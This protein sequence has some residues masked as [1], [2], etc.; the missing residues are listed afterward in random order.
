[1]LSKAAELNVKMVG[2]LP[3][4]EE[5]QA[6]GID[7]PYLEIFQFCNPADAMKMVAYDPIYSAYMPCR[8]ALSEDKDGKLWLLTLNMDL[9]IDKFPLPEEL[10]AIAVRVNG[11]I[12]EIMSAAST[13]DF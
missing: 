10:R 7:T 5:V 9:L 4:S 2:R 13:G 12:L 6:R 11:A 8:I 1:M 3:V